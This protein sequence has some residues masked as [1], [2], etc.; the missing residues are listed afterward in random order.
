MWLLNLIALSAFGFRIAFSGGDS[1]ESSSFNSPV[2]S[3]VSALGEVINDTA[4][5][6]LNLISDLQ[7]NVDIETKLVA[8]E[9]NLIGQIAARGLQPE[10]SAA[11]GKIV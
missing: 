11:A 8:L 10:E 4:K 7:N 9:N 5:D 6:V 1:F 2:S 3:S